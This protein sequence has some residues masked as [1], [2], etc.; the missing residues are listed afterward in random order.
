M[1]ICLFILSAMC[2]GEMIQWNGTLQS[3]NYPRGYPP[4]KEC[5]WTITVPERFQV[6][7]RFQ[8]FEMEKDS[9]CRYDYVEVR[10]G[11]SPE[12]ALLGKFCGYKI[13]PVVRSTSNK[14]LVKFRSDESSEY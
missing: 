12:N 10:D 14:L 11:H 4:N 13:P 1:I 7:L 2:G 6:A 3:T 5:L 9:E 8:M